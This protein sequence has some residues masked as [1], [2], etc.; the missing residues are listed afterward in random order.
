M[1]VVLFLLGV[2]LVAV[3]LRRMLGYSLRETLTHPVFIITAAGMAVRLLAS[4]L[5]IRFASDIAC[6]RAWADMLFRNGPAQFYV[7]EAF[8]D[9]PPGYMYILY[10]VGAVRNGFGIESG[11]FTEELLIK[12]PAMLADIALG[13]VIFRLAESRTTRRRALVASMAYVLN[14]AV[15]LI[16]ACWGQVDAVHTLLIVL[17]VCGLMDKKLLKASL[18]FVFAVLVKPQSLMFTPLF[19]FAYVMRWK[20]N[21]FK[22]AALLPLVEYILICLLSFCALILPFSTRVG[23]R[24]NVMPVL[25]Q[26]VATLSSYP[27]VSVNAYNFYALLGLNWKPITGTVLGMSYDLLGILALVMI[28]LISFYILWRMGEKSKSRYVLAAAF[29]NFSTFMFSVKMHERY[30]FPVMALLIVLLVLRNDKRIRQLYVFASAAFLLN[31]ADT[32]RLYTGELIMSRIEYTSRIFS[33]VTLVAYAA[34]LL[35]IYLA[36]GRVEAEAPAGSQKLP[37]PAPAPKK[38]QSFAA[39]RGYTFAIDKTE[40]RVRY[41][42]RDFIAMAV[43]TLVYAVVAF[44]RLGDTTAPQTGFWPETG[45]TFTIELAQSEPISR[46]QFYNGAR[47]NVTMSLAVSEDGTIWSAPEE[48]TVDSVFRWSEHTQMQSARFLRLTVTN[49]GKQL[50]EMAVRGADDKLLVPLRVSDNAETL[51]DEQA[52]VPAFSSFMNG[53][54]FDEIYHART[55]Y[56]YIEKLT[57][58]EWTH[59]PLGKV[60]IAAG[61]QTFGMTPF[62]WRCVGTLFGVLMLPLLYVFARRLF[63][64][65]EWAALATLF[66]AADFMHFAQTRISTID[67][68]ITFFVIAMYYFMYKYYTMSFFGEPDAPNGESTHPRKRKTDA[69]YKRTLVPLFLSGLCMGLGIACK[70]PGMYA[71]LGLAVLFFITLWKRYREYRYAKANEL[72]APYDQFVRYAVKTCLWCV[73]FFVVI[74][75]VIYLLS[76]IPYYLGG[77]LYPLREGNRLFREIPLFDAIL[78]DGAVGNFIGAVVQ[79]QRDIFGYHSKLVSDHPYASDWWSWILNIRPIFYHSR[80]VTQ[81]SLRQGISA[82]GNPL[83]WVGGLVSVFYCAYRFWGKYDKKHLFLFIAYLAQLLPWALVS[84]TTYIYHYFPSVPFL[85]LFLTYAV[86]DLSRRVKTFGRWIPVGAAAVTVVLFIMFY[87]VISGATVP[88]WYV[89]TFL[90]WLP[91]WQFIV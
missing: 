17:A 16:S 66:F 91:S 59:P 37:E 49:G 15:I 29:I 72:G 39:A 67:T 64:R 10:I 85:A 51:F 77:S 53:T 90:R 41:T 74:P 27:Y 23:L 3:A 57:V 6:F 2:M 12:L 69:A 65:T 34:L 24:F 33:M 86:R 20:E 83:V 68:Y 76:Y 18:F 28:V 55:A 30:S 9:Y 44:A 58:L 80:V 63:R 19:M 50:L 75:A 11:S 54:Y 14:P 82:F 42:N 81:E 56:E 40:K 73:L 78:P 47:N 87:P 31:F 22:P 25:E 8:T 4:L 48:L 45:E 52:F 5:P 88:A 70:W 71:G 36:G 84:R 46:L 61:V 26:Y 1:S 38:E 89:N 60:L 43:I 32:L 35:Y 7:S 21:G 79:N 62:G 13:V